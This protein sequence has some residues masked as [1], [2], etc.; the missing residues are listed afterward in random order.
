[1]SSMITGIKYNSNHSEVTIVRLNIND[2]ITKCQQSNFKYYLRNEVT[3]VLL[4]S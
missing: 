1:M 2:V 3:P 4:S